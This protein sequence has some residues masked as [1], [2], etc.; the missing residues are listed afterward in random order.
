MSRKE[1]KFSQTENID[2]ISIL[3]YLDEYAGKEYCKSSKR[4]DGNRKQMELNEAAGKKATNELRKMAELCEKHFNLK[5]AQANSWLDG[6]GRKLRN[7]LWIQLKAPGYENKP[8]SISLF[9]EKSDIQKISRFRFSFEIHNETAKEIPGEIERYHK[10]LEI[11][12]NKEKGMVYIAGSDEKGDITLID[13]PQ[14]KVRK[15]LNLGGY[16]KVQIS[17]IV[18][19]TEN[20]T[21]EECIKKM[22]KA[23]EDLLP[24]YEY[25][26]GK[27]PNKKEK[28][29]MMN[30]SKLDKFEKNMI[31]Y[32]PPGTGKT[33]STAIY[34]VAICDEKS[35]KE[36]KQEDYEKVMERYK[37]LK[38]E[39]RIAFTTFHQSYGYEEFIEG[40]KPV[41]DDED[42]NN[43][44]LEY[45]V[46]SG[47]FK[48][49]CDDV[50]TANIS[51]KTEI[52]LNASPTVWKV[53]LKGTGPNE[54]RKDCMENEHIR[55]GYDIY[56]E[57]ITN[58]TEYKEGGRNVLN[59]YISKMKK[60]DIVL[61]CYY[62]D[63]IDA[64]GVVTGDYEWHDEYDEYKRL[65]NVK[66][67]VKNIEHNILDINDNNPM[68]L[69]SVYRLNRILPAVALKIVEQY[70]NRNVTSGENKKYVFVIDEIN[71]GNIS[72]IFGELIT[73]I[74]SSK[75]IGEKEELRVKLPY[76]KPEFG[77]PNN[78]YILG[79]MNT[80][81]RSIALI[82]TALRRR[83]QF[84]EMMPEEGL[85]KE[86][87]MEEDLDISLMLAKINQRIEALYDREHTI[88]HAYFWELK[89]EP[90][91]EKLANI[92]EKR[93]IPLLQEYFY[94]DYSKIQ[95]ILSEKIIKK[96]PVEIRKLFKNNLEEIDLP[97]Y[98]YIID[99][100]ALREVESY[101]EIYQ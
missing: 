46:K 76:S 79:T 97:E 53:S 95:L 19:Q 6:S 47:V 4:T 71:R 69:L 68:T 5:R 54:V 49:F 39:G 74:E 22:L 99:K 98:K 88:G 14:E 34:A 17:E 48:K 33:Y 92:F 72:K 82:D 26:V 25:V 91:I 93:I 83:F 67:L 60:G 58:E 43:E 12:I 37:E 21:N 18:E 38:K 56:G 70:K 45:I 13:E 101:R 94:E 78:I 2:C 90:T 24:Y 57:D 41:M 55:I 10:H 36:V 62:A 84:I 7:Y 16:N 1:H 9:V 35:V 31:L 50:E 87:R 27:L 28:N 77:V 40:I 61:S 11:P 20:L 59:A 52:E 66:W 65:R 100:E 15:K 85:L 63:K 73:L 42:E 44:K 86:I 30:N 3:K 23:I 75:R 8:E 96:E 32:G 29:K 80:A 64:I 81:D 51:E 89:E